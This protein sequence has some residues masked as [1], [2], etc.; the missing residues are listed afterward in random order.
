[1][2]GAG[3]GPARWLAAAMA[4]WRT[5]SGLRVGM[6]RPW[7]WKALLSDGHVVPSSR[8]HGP[9]GA[10]LRRFPCIHRRRHPGSLE[11]GLDLLV[12]AAVQPVE[13]IGH[14]EAFGGGGIEHGGE[15]LGA[16]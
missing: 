12:L 3:G 10:V 13:D 8:V 5:A 1:M 4:R 7:R 2:G 16:H 9:V 15:E 6:P 11:D 14:G